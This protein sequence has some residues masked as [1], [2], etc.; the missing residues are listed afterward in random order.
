MRTLIR[1][2][3]VPFML[4]AINGT[5]IAI[6]SS[7]GHKLWLLGLLLLALASSFAAERVLPYR[8]DWNTSHDDSRRDA[9]HAA[10]NE[11]VTLGSVAALPIL[12]AIASIDGVW[13]HDWPFLVQVL[14]AVL[15]ADLGITL[16]H[17]AS[18]KIPA[19][20]RFHAVH[21][22]VKRAYGFNGLM[23]HPL[24]QTIETAA[25]VAP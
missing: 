3:Y 25:G 18:H 7:G 14:I 21:H 23:K 16:V 19:L 10:V 4:L 15:V 22:S 12:T 2:G 9:L 1:Y 13:P 8:Q 5:G 11:T 20:W 24:H 6:V 17:L